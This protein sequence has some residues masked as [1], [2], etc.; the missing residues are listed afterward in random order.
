M[1][2]RERLNDSAGLA[3]AAL[4]KWFASGAIISHKCH[5]P[6]PEPTN[7][8]LALH[9]RAQPSSAEMQGPWAPG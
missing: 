7:S 5:I 3:L 9:L 4:E 6:L 2:P 1:G 8:Q